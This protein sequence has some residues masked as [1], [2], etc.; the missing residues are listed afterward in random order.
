[1]M[2]RRT[3]VRGALLSA[4]MAAAIAIAGCGPQPTAAKS[5]AV[6]TFTSSAQGS[7]GTDL[8]GGLSA[9]PSP[10]AAPAPPPAA[11][12]PPPA[13]PPAPAV[14]PECRSGGLRLGIGRGS[15]A[16]GHSYQALEFTNIGSAPCVLAGFPGVSYVSGDNGAQ[17][18]APAQRDGGIG[19][20]VV[21][22]PGATASAIVTRVDVG[23]FDP[24]SCRPTPVRG[25]RVYPPD[26][27]SSIF[28]PLDGT[29]CAGNPPEAQLHVQ[30][31]KSGVGSV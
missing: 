11:A 12:N 19:P 9:S 1:M 23:V 21:L 2:T 4:G 17:V 28:V 24:G 22:A 5:A 13:A 27:R 15:A 8:S 25:L 10:S 3:I 29:G 14:T 16:A 31:I 18:G 26:E 20:Q 6:P 7:P 30:T